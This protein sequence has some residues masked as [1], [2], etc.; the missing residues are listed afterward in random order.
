M[1]C[2]TCLGAGIL[3]IPPAALSAALE[4]QQQQ[5]QR[6]QR[7]CTS[8]SRDLHSTTVAVGGGEGGSML[9]TGIINNK[10]SSSTDTPTNNALA[11]IPMRKLDVR[12]GDDEGNNYSSFN[13][14]NHNKGGKDE[15]LRLDWTDKIRIAETKWEI[16]HD[17]KKSFPQ[18][19]EAIEQKSVEYTIRQRAEEESSSMTT[20]GSI[21]SN[22]NSATNIRRRSLERVRKAERKWGLVTPRGLNLAKRIEMV[23]EAATSYNRRL[24]RC[25]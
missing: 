18:R 22:D 16:E 7:Q 24:D 11:N 10:L 20:A 1:Q 2:D 17:E 13:N 14:N 5:K 6:G 8:P 15:D 9:R 21:S 23:E 19:I 3:P 25:L 4:Q 12:E